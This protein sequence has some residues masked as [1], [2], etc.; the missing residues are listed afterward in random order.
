MAILTKNVLMGR[1]LVAG[2]L[3]GEL[4][5]S[6]LD[7]QAGLHLDGALA[8]LLTKINANDA[9]GIAARAALQADVDQNEADA[10]A[11]LAAATTELA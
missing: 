8:S 5:V 10:D 1:D 4:L 3:S 11:G 6:T 9:A 7:G 2:T